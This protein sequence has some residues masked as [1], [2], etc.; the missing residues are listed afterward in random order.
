MKKKFIT[1][2]FLLSMIAG[3]SSFAGS[4]ITGAGATFPYPIYSKWAHQYHKKTGIKL[5]Y[6]SIG[7]GGGVKQIKAKTV[8]FGASDAPLKP[9]QLKKYGLIQF[10]MIVG[11]VVPVVN[12]KGLEEKQ[13]KLTPEVLADIFSGNITHWNDSQLTALN[14]GLILPN[15][16]ITVVHRA[17]GS[18]TT[19]IF[20]NYLSKVNNHWR[21][22]IGNAKSVQWPVGI[23]GKGNEG[24]AAF[25]NKVSGSIGYVEYAYAL[26]NKMATVLLKNVDNQFVSATAESFQAAAANADWENA[27]NY[28]VV[29]TNQPGLNSWPIAGASFILLHNEQRR[30]EQAKKV[31]EF[32]SWSYHHGQKMATDLDYV[33]I[34]D[35][36]VRQV[37][38]SWTDQVRDSNG[39]VI[40]AQQ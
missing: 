31:L 10:P 33:P 3:Q 34:P 39:K 12:I 35:S 36:V 1:T 7:S 22:N 19:W 6:Q 28:F 32:F 20:T 11:G 23:G 5:N 18:G 38:K 25:V 4:Q 9:T 16:E 13:I 24:V 2:L 14:P 8:D 27:E 15:K 29:L 30:P 37:E 21:K 17:D 40:W 26:Q